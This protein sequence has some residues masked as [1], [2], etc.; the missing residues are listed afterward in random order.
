MVN[1]KNKL[2]K[3][4]IIDVIFT[5]GLIGLTI[6]GT[7]YVFPEVNNAKVETIEEFECENAINCSCKKNKCKC[8]RDYCVCTY[9]TD[10]ACNIVK[11]EVCNK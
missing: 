1:E 4:L 6:I 7:I 8:N 3:E 9:C 11:E 5:L 2:I 10:D